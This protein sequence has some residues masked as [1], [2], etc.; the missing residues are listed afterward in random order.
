M[1]DIGFK[2]G[3]DGINLYWQKIHEEAC[4]KDWTVCHLD[5]NKQNRKV[6]LDVVESNSSPFDHSGHKN[7]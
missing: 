6:W 7:G 1:I 2:D 5:D 3:I 4:S